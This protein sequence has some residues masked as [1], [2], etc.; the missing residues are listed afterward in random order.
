MAETEIKVLLALFDRVNIDMRQIVDLRVLC[1]DLGIDPEQSPQIQ[2]TL[3]FNELI[4]GH[5]GDGI[6]ISRLGIG[7]ARIYQAQGV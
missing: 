3:V 6:S 1:G 7:A 4:V 5:G 2:R